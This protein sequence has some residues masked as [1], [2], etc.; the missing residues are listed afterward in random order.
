MMVASLGGDKNILTNYEQV[1]K[2]ANHRGD[3][4]SNKNGYISEIKTRQLGLCLIE[5]GGGRKQ[6]SDKIDYSVGL[7]N[8]KAINNKIK[9]GD[10]LVTALTRNE[11]DFKK[12][13]KQL[14]G[15]FI[16]KDKKIANKNIIDII[17]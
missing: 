5:I 6:I 1:I 9:K 2:I 17:N 14:S 7:V 10:I 16:I 11:N 4:I 15:S 12:I 3:I 13:E 8:V